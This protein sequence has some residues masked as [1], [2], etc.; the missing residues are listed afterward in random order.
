MLDI[1]RN[2]GSSMTQRQCSILRR[3]RPGECYGLP[4]KSTEVAAQI[5]AIMR[6]PLQTTRPGLPRKALGAHAS[7]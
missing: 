4:M 7:V 5:Y 1:T 2:P 3:K 6:L